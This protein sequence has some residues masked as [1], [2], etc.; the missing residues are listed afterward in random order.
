[1]SERTV[2]SL[3]TF[4]LTEKQLFI[5]IK[6]KQ[7]IFTVWHLLNTPLRISAKMRPISASINQHEFRWDMQGRGPTRHSMG[8]HWQVWLTWSTRSMRKHIQNNSV[9]SNMPQTFAMSLCDSQQQPLQRTVMCAHP[10]INTGS[11]NSCYCMWSQGHIQ[12]QPAVSSCGF[13]LKSHHWYEHV[14][15]EIKILA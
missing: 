6:M 11:N 10:I 14:H 13:M 15:L 1:M 12:Q 7:Y 8:P 5:Y 4:W 9:T 3:Q 2:V